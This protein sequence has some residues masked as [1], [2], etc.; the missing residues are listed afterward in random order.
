[1]QLLAAYDSGMPLV[2]IDT[3]KDQPDRPAGFGEL[4]G[5]VVYRTMGEAL[6]VPAADNF[7]IATEHDATGLTYDPSYLGIERT[8]GIVMIS[9]T[10]NAGRT[11]EMKQAF[12]ALLADRLHE[13]LGVR[14]GDV[15][16]GLTEV[17]KENWSFGDGIAQYA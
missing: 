16:V 9:I 8:D 12:F 2:R 7:R 5:D 13:E 10:L 3:R 4:V 11:T 6:G 1:M 15:F 14:K 17:S